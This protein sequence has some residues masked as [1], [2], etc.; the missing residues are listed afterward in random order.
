MGQ[1]KLWWQKLTQIIA[2]AAIMLTNKMD[3]DQTGEFNKTRA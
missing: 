2:A 1:R 3:N